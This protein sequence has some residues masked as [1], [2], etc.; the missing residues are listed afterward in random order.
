VLGPNVAVT[1]FAALIATVQTFP[2]TLVHPAQLAK[3]EVASGVAVRTTCVAG[4]VFGTLTVQPVVEPLVH[5]IPSAVTVPLPVPDVFAVSSHVLGAK[6]AV[7]DLAP[8]IE[9][10]HR[11]PETLVQPDQLANTE[12]ASGVAVRTTCVAGVVFGTL[13]V[14]PSVDPL[15]QEIPSPV[16]VPL[17]VPEVLAVSRYVLGAKLAVTVFAALIVIVQTFPET[18]VHPVQLASFELASGVAVSVTT[19][20]GEVSGTSVVQPAVEPDVQEIPA[21]VTVPF[22]VPDVPTVSFTPF[23][24]VAVT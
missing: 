24:N 8:V 20:A 5:E 14:Q 11:L 16:T 4:V 21:P 13:T 12:V 18:L 15:V 1:V 23:S 10:V 6:V 19:C 2:E 22:P 3:T 7:T 9:T 17:P